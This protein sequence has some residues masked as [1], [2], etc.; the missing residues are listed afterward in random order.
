MIDRIIETRLQRT[1]ATNP[2]IILQFRAE[3]SG[4]T[5]L[6]VRA[7][8]NA[9][10]CMRPCTRRAQLADLRVHVSACVTAGQ[11]LTGVDHLLNLGQRSAV[12]LSCPSAWLRFLSPGRT[13]CTNRRSKPRERK[14]AKIIYFESELIHL[15]PHEPRT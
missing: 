4:I 9:V 11:I 12:P 8:D 5:K 7:F 13:F 2:I 1:I 15:S 6:R 3:L 10:L 14:L